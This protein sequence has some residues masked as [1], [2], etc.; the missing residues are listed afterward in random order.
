[1]RL[2]L[3]TH[4]MLWWALDD[5]RLG[6]EAR[7]AIA[8]AGD[9]YVSAASIWE[10]AIKIGLG[11]LELVRFETADLPK[12]AEQLG[13]L[14]LAITAAHAALVAG[15]PSHH[16]DPFDRLLIAQAKLESL[17]V[18]TADRQFAPYGVPLL[19]AG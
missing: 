12:L 7:R 17:V 2:L 4:V 3:D 8:D 9:V 13:F 15:L 10:M 5:R 11:K 16:T 1:V 14:D 19:E 6:T 18:V